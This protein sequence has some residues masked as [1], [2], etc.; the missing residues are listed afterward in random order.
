LI[1]LA[2]RRD[3]ST[4]VITVEAVVIKYPGW[5]QTIPFNSIRE[6][7][8]HDVHLRGNTWAAVT[9]EK[10][11][12]RAIKLFRFREGSVALHHALHSAWCSATGRP[13]SDPV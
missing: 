9:M 2:I 8:L 3:P 11:E 1:L 7:A 10:L 4:V 5:G 13:T 6:I 12:G